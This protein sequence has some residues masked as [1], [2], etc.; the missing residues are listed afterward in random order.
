M[1]RHAATPAALFTLG[2]LLASCSATRP[3][4]S[5]ADS[6]EP[7][8]AGIE[9]SIP[10]LQELAYVAVALTPTGQADSNMVDMTT[11]YYTEAMEHFRLWADH[12]LIDTLAAHIRAPR[13]MDSY[14][15][16]YAVV[17]NACAYRFEGERILPE[18]PDPPLGFDNVPDPIRAHRGLFEDFARVSGFRD[19]HGRHLPYYDS[20]KATY[21]DLNPVGRMQQWLEGRFGFGYASYTICFGP[22]VGGAHATTSARRGRVKHTTMFVSRAEPFADLGENLNRMIHSRVVFTEIDHNFVNPESRRFRRSIRRALVDR[23]AWVDDSRD[24][25]LAYD[26]AQAVFNEYMTWS[27][28][29]LYCMDHYPEAD[30]QDFLPR[31]ERQMV[32]DRGFIR[33]RE[34]NRALADEY[35]NDPAADGRTLVKAMV[36]WCAHPAG[37]ENPAAGPAGKGA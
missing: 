37:A 30:V 2:L 24:G 9:L 26:S 20:L 12:A 25:A 16:Y 28:F 4:A 5:A 14:G 29:S 36:D 22:L 33:F 27:L 17:M 34:F 13:D 23:A 11:A 1:R 19:F 32:E 18:R 35:R 10:E 15:Y 3:T 8:R 21:G 6:A 7:R 31:M